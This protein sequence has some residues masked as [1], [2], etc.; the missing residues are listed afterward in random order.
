MRNPTKNLDAREKSGGKN[1][2]RAV[3]P[4]RGKKQPTGEATRGAGASQFTN[5]ILKRKKSPSSSIRGSRRHQLDVETSEEMKSMASI[6]ITEAK[7][8]A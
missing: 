5:K 7:Q 8:W 4:R 6:G 2:K 3:T 1:P